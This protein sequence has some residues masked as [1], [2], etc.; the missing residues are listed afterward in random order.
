MYRAWEQG[1][2]LLSICNFAC[3]FIRSDRFFPN[4]KIEIIKNTVSVQAVRIADCLYVAAY[5][6]QSLNGQVGLQV[7]IQ[8]PSIYLIRQRQDGCWQVDATDPTHKQSRLALR[9][10]G[11]EIKI[12]FP[13]S[14]PQEKRFK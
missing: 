2:C 13:S 11:K 14:H 7:G 10:N 9:I 5:E 4:T 3:F 12:V 1:Q 8:M 6:P